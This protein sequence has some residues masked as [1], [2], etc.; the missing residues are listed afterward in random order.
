MLCYELELLTNATVIDDAIRFLSSN[1]KVSSE[2]EDERSV[3][4]R[5]FDLTFKDLTKKVSLET[6]T[7][8]T[9]YKLNGATTINLG[10][11]Y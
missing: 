6:E 7:T 3:S 8:S 11:S 9:V 4:A 10:I 5:F 1:S 2:K